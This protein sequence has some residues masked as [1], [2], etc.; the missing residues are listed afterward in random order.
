MPKRFSSTAIKGTIARTRRTPVSTRNFVDIA[1]TLSGPSPVTI[2]CR[3]GTYGVLFL[4]KVRRAGF[5][6][7]LRVEPDGSELQKLLRYDRVT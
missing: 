4:Q 3:C 2:S 7:G 5:E 1:E 6:C